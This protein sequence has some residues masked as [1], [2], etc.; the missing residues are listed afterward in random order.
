MPKMP[1]EITLVNNKHFGCGIVGHGVFSEI[2][3]Q[4]LEAPTNPI[5][6][7]KLIL[8]FSYIKLR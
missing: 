2:P 3:D 4:F 1:E 8:Y 7:L 5:L 6:P